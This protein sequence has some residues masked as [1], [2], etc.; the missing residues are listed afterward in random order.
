M[1]IRFL[2]SDTRSHA[3]P[4]LGD[5]PV[6]ASQNFESTGPCHQVLDSFLGGN[7]DEGGKKRFWVPESKRRWLYSYGGLGVVMGGESRREH[8]FT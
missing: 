5:P 3:G 1:F 8:G 6:S 2:F 7:V 4:G